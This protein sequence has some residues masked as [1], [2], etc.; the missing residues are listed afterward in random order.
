[1]KSP[2]SRFQT[3]ILAGSLVVPL[4]GVAAFAQSDPPGPG[5]HAVALPTRASPGP[6]KEVKVLLETPHLKLA[7][8]TLRNGTRLEEHSAPTQVSIQALV[9][10]GSVQMGDTKQAISNGQMI[11]L[12]PGLAHAVTPDGKQDLVL[13]VHHL[14]SGG[15]PGMGPG[16]A[17]RRGTGPGA[18]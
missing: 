5:F 3:W 10:S 14:K 15:R 11:V 16:P 13:L 8:I 1:M 6:N 18:P 12:A 17:Q 4:A 7:S 9:G 2:L